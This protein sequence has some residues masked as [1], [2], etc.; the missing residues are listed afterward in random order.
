MLLLLLFFF[1]I[2]LSLKDTSLEKPQKGENAYLSAT[3]NTGAGIL[4]SVTGEN[5]SIPRH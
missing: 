4:F 2:I 3:W 1:L 5:G